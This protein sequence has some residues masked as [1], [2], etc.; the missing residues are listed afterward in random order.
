MARRSRDLTLLCGALIAV[1][2]CADPGSH[3]GSDTSAPAGSVALPTADTTQWRTRRLEVAPAKFRPGGWSSEDALWGLVGGRLTRLDTRTGAVRTLPHEAW[4]IHAAAGVVAWRNG[5]GTWLLRDDGEPALVAPAGAD[6]ATGF[7]G[8]P[9]VLWSPDG[10]RALLAW[11]GEW[12][13]A[14]DLLERDG[15]RRRLA[16]TIPGYYGSNAALW[17]DSTRVLF[18]VVAK[19][20]IAGE[21][22]YRESGWRGD[23]AVL[24]V[25]N[26]AYRL[27][28]TVPDSIFL[29]VA[30]P[31]PD[32]VLVTEWSS[33][34][35]RERWLYDPATWRRH[36]TSLPRGRAFASRAGAVVILRDS[37]SD[38]TGAVLVS[39]GK[40]MEIGR[41][42]RDGE[43]AFSP[44]GRR[45][46]IRTADGTMLLEQPQE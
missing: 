37:Q 31:H 9:T 7:D 20:P 21:P 15:S 40:T 42:P 23:L 33:S 5:R 22:E 11:A 32:G 17:L 46:A 16:T 25:R 26:G 43:P 1:A 38:T 35:V 13:A 19:G 45:G 29:R 6:S 36:P 2:A 10:S 12:D 8:P 14:Y 39:G 28:T 18:Q 3:A 41:V 4:S 27:V 44:S 24:E 30:G 34:G